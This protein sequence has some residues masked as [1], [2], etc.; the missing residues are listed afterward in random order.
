MKVAGRL[1]TVIRGTV[2]VVLMTTSTRAFASGHLPGGPLILVAI[3][4]K[5]WPLVLAGL[6]GL[7]TLFG[8]PSGLTSVLGAAS[9]AVGTI[10]AL[11]FIED[12][13]PWFMAIAACGL[14]V[15]G[16]HGVRLVIRLLGRATGGRARET[17]RKWW[18][19]L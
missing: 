4:L 6:V 18:R 10:G 9:S 3:L 19:Y 12:S 1:P 17:L 11:L 8:R 15:I 13:S 16:A 2:F 7:I 14:V 5:L